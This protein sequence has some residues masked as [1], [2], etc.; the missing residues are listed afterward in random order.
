MNRTTIIGNL[1]GDA[2]L[3]EHNG[4][5]FLYFS[6]AYSEKYGDVERTDWYKCFIQKESTINGKIIDYLKK[7]TKVLIEGRLTARNWTTTDGKLMLDYVMN[8]F[9][10]EL[11]GSSSGAGSDRNTPPD[12]PGSGSTNNQPNAGLDPQNDFNTE[13]QDDDLP[14]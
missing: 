12:M 11:L 6:I 9:A 3:K 5:K 13:K 2:E 8:V 10:V 7:G 4:K 14:F 1:G